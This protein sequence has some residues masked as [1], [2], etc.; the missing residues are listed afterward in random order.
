MVTSTID[1]L[2]HQRQLPGVKKWQLE[3]GAWF[4]NFNENPALW[5]FPVLAVVGALLNVA[6]SKTK[7]LWFCVLPLFINHGKW[8][9]HCWQYQCS[10]FVMPSSTHQ[11]KALLMWDATSSELTLNL[12]FC[13]ISIRYH[14]RCFTPLVILQ[15]VWSLG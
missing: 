6:A 3:T 13:S 14:P 5:A 12:M 8:D 4:K 15:N 1:H 7:S 10:P 9:H 11:N 2:Q